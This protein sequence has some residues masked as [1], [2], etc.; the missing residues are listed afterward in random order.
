[1]LTII[2]ICDQN[3]LDNETILSESFVQDS[4]KKNFQIY[5]IFSL[6]VLY[7]FPENFVQNVQREFWYYQHR[8]CNS[9]LKQLGE[10]CD[11]D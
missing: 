7:H 5:I 11:F 4:P 6:N 8:N 2:L 9:E 1:M 10:N 3:F